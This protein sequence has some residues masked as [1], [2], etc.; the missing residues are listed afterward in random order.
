M[1]DLL[2]FISPELDSNGNDAQRKQ[3]RAKVGKSFSGFFC[4]LDF[5]SPEL[6]TN[7]LS[8]DLIKFTLNLIMCS[9]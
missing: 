9:S 8:I 4:Q 3:R 7:E 6:V 2:D 1:S 5:M